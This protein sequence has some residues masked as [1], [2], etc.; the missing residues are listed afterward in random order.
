M[1]QSNVCRKSLKIGKR[2]IYR[3]FIKIFIYAAVKSKA[4]V[5]VKP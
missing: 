3:L 4:T 5:V 2:R 1:S